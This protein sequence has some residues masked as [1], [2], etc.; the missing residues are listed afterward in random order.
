MRQLL[1]LAPGVVFR[2]S[3]AGLPAA[4]DFSVRGSPLGDVAV[5]VDGAPARSELFG[6]QELSLGADALAEA[7]LIT[8][9]PDLLAADARGG[10]VRYVTR[11]G[12]SIS[13]AGLRALTD[14]P[15]GNGSSVGFNRFEAFAGGPL[16]PRGAAGRAGLS[17]F[18]SGTLQGQLGQ[19]LGPGAADQP[20]YVLGPADT[21]VQSVTVPR[22]VP[23]GQ[24]LRRPDDWSTLKR[25]QAKLAY[26][27]GAGSSVS[28][29]VLGSDVARRFF[30]GQALGDPALYGG[31]RSS[32][33]LGVLDWNHGL[34]QGVDGAL[35]LSVN[36]SYGADRQVGG[37]LD[38]ASELATRDPSLGIEF[39][40][41]KFVGTDSIPNPL[42]EQIIRNIRSNTGL[43]TP[44]LN[45]V[46][47]RNS[48]PYRLNPYGLSVGW[49]TNGLD[50]SLTMVWERRLNGRGSLEWTGGMHR[51]T[52]GLDATRTDLSYYSAGLIT[53]FDLDAVLAHPRRYGIFAGD[54]LTSGGAVVDVGLRYDHFSPG[55]AFSHVPGRIITDPA[56]NS[57]GS[58]TAYTN[59]VRRV[60]VDGRGQGFVSPR[61]RLM[62]AFGPGTSVRAAIGRQVEPPTFRQLFSNV[63]SDLSFTATSRPFGR[64]VDYAKSTLVELGAR[65]VVSDA[66]SADIAIYHKTEVEPYVYFLRGFDDPSNPGSTLYVNSL[67]RLKG[68]GSGIDA[69]LDW[70]SGERLNGSVSYSLIRADLVPSDGV[71]FLGT[72]ET[73]QQ[74]SIIGTLRPPS[75]WRWALDVEALVTLRLTS[76]IPYSLLVNMGTGLTVP[77]EL[78]PL[79]V[80]LQGEGRLPWTKSVDLR[81]TKG[82]LAGRFTW[83]LYADARNLLNFT[84]H[85][86]AYAETATDNNALFRANVLSPEVASMALE[87]QAQ[88][89]SKLNSDGSINLGDCTQWT[90]TSSSTIDCVA[91]QRVEQRFGNGDHVYTV[92]EQTKALGAYFDAFFGAWRFHGA[93][94]TVRVGLEL[95]F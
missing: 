45:R 41:M 43:R 93:G 7:T 87:A 70:R 83:T 23:F 28:V 88:P 67:T 50:G 56:W 75:G 63:N 36:L 30:P 80:D 94:R 15:F 77:G 86:G 42:T 78:P 39:S 58:D 84:N 12:D 72:N 44:F 51:V 16:G 24:G 49:P 65:Q 66:L 47:L 85:I 40:T 29:T 81:V 89:V 17:W 11:V 62:Y 92:A 8:G 20:T 73:Q 1:G 54:R 18:V 31:A 57:P 59:S 46:D 82:I 26:T 61:V 74:L 37:L 91:L 79:G 9:V 90:G 13:T 19:Y 69:R 38:P 55:A 5:Y 53:T 95:A 25:G 21:T 22:Y 10:V 4:A 33:R 35:R 3:S 48:Q 68:N 64:D 76:G 14:E 32:S 71:V 27:Y 34:R 6:T 2:G 52:V 60:F